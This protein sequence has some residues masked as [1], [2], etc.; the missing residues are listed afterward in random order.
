[1][2]DDRALL[3]ELLDEREI[4]RLMHRYTHA[5]DYGLDEEYVA[6][7][8]EDGVFDVIH[9]D[10]TSWHREEGHEQ[11]RA[12]VAT[13]PKPPAQRRKHLV[14]SPVITVTGDTAHAESYLFCLKGDAYPDLYIFGRYVDELVR[15]DGRWLL[16]E[17]RAEVE[18]S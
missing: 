5:L 16:K 15:V 7:Y 17:R 6:L 3:Q 4:L 8:T 2:S 18:A 10:G 9:K 1:M 13:Y 12:W 11:I 14:L